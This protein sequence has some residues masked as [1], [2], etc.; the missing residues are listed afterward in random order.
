MNVSVHFHVI[1]LFP[2]VC[3]AYT[4]ASVLG[5]AQKGR[6]AKRTIR[7]SYYNPRD[8]TKDKH[9]KV[10]D[11]PYGGG[12]GMVLQVEPILAAVAKALGRKGARA[13]RAKTKIIL[14]SPRGK[15]FDRRY[16]ARLARAQSDIVLIAGRYEGIDGRVKKILRPEEVSVGPYT[17]M[18]GELPALIVVDAV[19]RHIAGV[20]GKGESLE[21]TR[22]ASGEVYTRPETFV[23]KGKKYHV[24]KALLTGDHQEI[25]KWRAGRL[26]TG[27][28]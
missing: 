6:G 25:E 5:R 28:A 13:G 2:E 23:Y 27:P 11:R 12:P 4:D 19:A 24:P 3:K 18:G 17:L 10:D 15:Q 20:L 9:R 22:A 8:Y 7:V 21:E 1:T 26:S 14:L 16:A